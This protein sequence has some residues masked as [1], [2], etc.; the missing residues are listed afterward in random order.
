M[1]WGCIGPNCAG[2]LALCEGM[3]N[4]QYYVKVL[5][6]NLAESARKIYS[7]EN[8]NVYF[9]RIMLHAIKVTANFLNSNRI[10]TMPWPAQSMD[11]HPI[12]NVW[13]F[14]KNISTYMA[15]M[16]LKAYL[17]CKMIM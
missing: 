15:V 14:M 8:H 16:T 9:S 13:P 4:A 3:I 17:M 10:L 11:R 7:N 12:E 1:V 5:R 2:N 6:E